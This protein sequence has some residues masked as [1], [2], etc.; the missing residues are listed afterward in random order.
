[1]HHKGRGD[2]WRHK[3]DERQREQHGNHHAAE[4]DAAGEPVAQRPR[5]R[6]VETSECDH[7]EIPPS[8]KISVQRE[9]ENE[10][11]SGNQ[12]I[13]RQRQQVQDEGQPRQPQHYRTGLD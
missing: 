13:E 9:K 10:I 8:E 6:C 5:R 4:K 1:M 2:D 11:Y 7:F 12:Q 3:V